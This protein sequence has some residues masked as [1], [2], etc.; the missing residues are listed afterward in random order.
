MDNWGILLI[1]ITA[2]MVVASKIGH[3][4]KKK[5]AEKAEDVVREIFLQNKVEFL[6]DI[7]YHGGLP[8]FPKPSML[9]I[10]VSPDGLFMCDYKGWSDKVYFRTWLSVEKFIVQEKADTFGKS[11]V[12]LGP[13]VPILFKDKLRYFV[14]VKYIDQDQEQNHLVLE[15]GTEELQQSICKKLF[16]FSGKCSLSS[17]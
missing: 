9:V 13:L 8:Q 3:R 11:T 14:T 4:Q 16:R 10:G 5:A 7:A 2:C 12:L 1:A 15:T 17:I 6:G